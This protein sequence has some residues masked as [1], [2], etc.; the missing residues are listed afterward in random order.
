MHTNCVKCL[1]EQANKLFSKHGLPDNVSGDIM[2][3]L[4]LFID[5]RKAEELSIIEAATFLHR[6]LKKAA[7][8][9]DLYKKK[10]MITT[11]YYWNLK[12]I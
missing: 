12:R 2:V 8:T 9:N 3:R 7:H 6:L 1:L 5:N 10:R 11:I 4:Q